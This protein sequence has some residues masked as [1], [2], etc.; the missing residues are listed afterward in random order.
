MMGANDVII[1]PEK[2]LKIKCGNCGTEF[3]LTLHADP[4]SGGW[5][6]DYCP[7]CG[8]TPD[9]QVEPDVYPIHR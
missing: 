2:P 7:F 3:S 6:L 9:P 5:N 8:E 1:N 4:E